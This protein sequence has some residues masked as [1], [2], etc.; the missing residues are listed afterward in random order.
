VEAEKGGDMIES[1]G[2]TASD[3]KFI[4]KHGV[5]IFF[6]D[7]RHHHDT[8]WALLKARGALVVNVDEVEHLEQIPQDRTVI[9]YSTSPGDERS[10]RTAKSLQQH[11]WRD[12]HFLVGG[13]DA[14]CEA[15]L[16]V[17]DIGSARAT[18]K[19]MLL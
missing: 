14:Y 9:V 6:I 7:D 19:I 18:K 15:G 12:A 16:P 2:V 5:K 10:S 13:F 1:L 4:M 3:V 11:G 17:E 8:D